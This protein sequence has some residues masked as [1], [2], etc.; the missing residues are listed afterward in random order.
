[1]DYGLGQGLERRLSWLGLALVKGIGPLR[2]KRELDNY[3]YDPVKIWNLG[4]EWV[5]TR[6]SDYAAKEYQRIR[7]EVCLLDYAD[8]LKHKGIGF[9]TLD[10]QRYPE[11]LTDIYDPPPVL[12][13]R[14]QI[15][16]FKFSV[17]IVGSRK[18]RQYGKRATEELSSQLAARGVVIVSGLAKGIDRMAHKAALD[19]GGKT[20][21]VL[22]SGHDYEYPAT[23]RDLYERIPENGVI[24]SEFPPDEPPRAENF[25]R[26]N[27]IISGL[28]QAVL[29]V[30]AAQ[31]SGSLITANLAV[32]Q[33]RDVMA[34]PGD[35]YAKSSRGTNDL[36]KN[37]AQLVTSVDDILTTISGVGQEHRVTEEL[38]SENLPDLTDSENKLIK[39]FT[40]NIELN[41]EEI[42]QLINI[43]IAELNAALVK[44]EIKGVI[45]RDNGHNYYFKGL[46][47]LLKPI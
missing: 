3:N 20:V 9:V 31:K 2:L 16:D 24:F 7:D 10:D 8:D 42:S 32:E 45:A 4:Q 23:N 35:I 19:A 28:S 43:E 25:P 39:I 12:F 27:R 34:V 40:D 46:Q 14:G 15:P 44:L 30:E 11:I 5:R 13:Y 37:G 33:N 21:A 41:Y 18:F 17:A 38:K 26:R 1:M 36:I 47:N 22:G 6:F 29:V